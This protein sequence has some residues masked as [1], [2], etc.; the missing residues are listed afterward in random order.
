MQK[1]TIFS[2]SFSNEEYGVFSRFYPCV[3]TARKLHPET[4][5]SSHRTWSRIVTSAQPPALE[6]NHLLNRRVL[7]VRG[8]I[9][10]LHKCSATTPS[11]VENWCARSG[12]T[13]GG[14]RGGASLLPSKLN[15]K[16]GPP[17][18]DTLIFSILL[19]FS[20]LSFFCVFRGVFVFLAGI[21]IHDIRIHY[22][23]LTFFLGVGEWPPNGGQWAPS[24]K[25]C[26]SGSNL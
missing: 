3:R 5:V 20:R 9:E 18:V 24:A 10:F 6:T 16:N 8:K 23:F 2:L 26:P 4:R 25:F 19:V 1:P 14:A 17:S 22:H 21:D 11:N 13:D 7:L 12:V 15:V